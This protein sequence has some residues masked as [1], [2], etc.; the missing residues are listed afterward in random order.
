MRFVQIPEFERPTHDGGT[1]HQRDLLGRYTVLYVYPKA[2]TPGCTREALDFTEKLPQFRRLGARVYGISPDSC[3]AQ[4]RFV[5]GR[6]L[7]VTM[8]SDPE[9]SLAHALGAVKDS[10]GIL[11]STFLLDPTGAVRWSWR[12]VKV[13]GHVEDVLATLEELRAA[14]AQVLRV[15]EARRARRALSDEPVTPETIDTLLAAAHLAPSCFNKQPWRFVVIDDDKTLRE[16]KKALSGGNYWAKPAPAI[17]ALFSRTDLD[18]RLS[19]ERDYFLFGCGLAVSNLMLQA[20]AMGLVAHPIA[21]YDPMEVKKTLDAP[22]DYTLITLVIVAHP[23]DP[24]TLSD[25][26]RATELGPRDRK[27]ISAVRADNRFSFDA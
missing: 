4:A 26:H 22:D 24:Q 8:L 23:G 16:V 17:L 18:C 6:Q 5:V 12:G 2:N 3:D 1:L 20:T 13:P 15:I 19:D 11:R 9:R 21:G 25:K 27:P 7:T 14:D 10:G